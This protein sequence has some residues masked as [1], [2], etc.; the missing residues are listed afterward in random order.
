MSNSNKFIYGEAINR[1]FSEPAYLEKLLT[2]PIPALAETGVTV[3][4]GVGVKVSMNGNSAG[5][6]LSIDV[7]NAAVDWVG[8]VNLT[9]HK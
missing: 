3:D 8:S 7:T 4:K 1:A 2:D 6:A 5:G 9:L